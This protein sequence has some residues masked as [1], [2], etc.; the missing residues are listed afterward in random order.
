VNEEDKQNM[1][2]RLTSIKQG[3]NWWLTEVNIAVYEKKEQAGEDMTSLGTASLT[4]GNEPWITMQ[5]SC[6]SVVGFIMEHLPVIYDWV[7]EFRS[8]CVDK[9]KKS[10]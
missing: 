8:K 1:F 4:Y 10:L 9:P 6:P 5:C 7:D 2:L 3:D